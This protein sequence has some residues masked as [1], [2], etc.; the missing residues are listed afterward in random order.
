MVA[1]GRGGGKTPERVVKLLQEEVTRTSQAATARATGLTLQTVQRYIK[2]IGEPSQATLEKLADYFETS[3][4]WL[5][6]EEPIDLLEK[7]SPEEMLLFSLRA[8]FPG[9]E[10]I[11]IEELTSRGFDSEVANEFFKTIKKT[12]TPELIAKGW[13]DSLAKFENDALKPI[14]DEIYSLF[15]VE[16]DFKAEWIE[17]TARDCA[18]YLDNDI[19]KPMIDE[20]NNLPLSE[21]PSAAAIIKQFANNS[22]FKSDVKQLLNNSVAHSK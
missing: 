11:V 8:N 22:K 17:K 1:K 12:F 18:A 10:K 2:G 20:I 14:I 4:A 5:R 15:V 19:I 6:S 3:V 16:K 9:G 21:V 7:I 13:K